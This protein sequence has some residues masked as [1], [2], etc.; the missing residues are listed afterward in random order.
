MIIPIFADENVKKLIWQQFISIENASCNPF[1]NTD[2]INANG[3]SVSTNN[4][5]KRK[6]KYKKLR[7][8]ATMN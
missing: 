1:A 2:S 7:L 3:K 6:K 8:H 5:T 4:L